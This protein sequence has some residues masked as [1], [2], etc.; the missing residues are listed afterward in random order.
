MLLLTIKTGIVDH[1]LVY[2]KRIIAIINKMSLIY[3]PKI[4]VLQSF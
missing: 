4:E 2:K 3:A 1:C